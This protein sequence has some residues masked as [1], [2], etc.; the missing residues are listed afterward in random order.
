LLGKAGGFPSLRKKT[1]L[2]SFVQV[3]HRTSLPRFYFTAQGF[4]NSN[5]CPYAFADLNVRKELDLM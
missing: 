3:F 4:F 1:H 2:D 5:L